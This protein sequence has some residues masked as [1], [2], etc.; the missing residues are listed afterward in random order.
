[1]ARELFVYWKVGHGSVP[2]AQ[3]AAVELLQ[4]V[5]E[6]HPGLKTRLML[7]ADE[8]G[9]GGDRATFMETYSAPAPGVTTAVQA[10]IEAWAQ[11]AF[12]GVGRPARHVEVFESL[13]V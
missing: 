3:L 10:A 1:M 7:R 6:V 8:A 5:H 4:A 12:A 13:D 11:I 2:A 9:E